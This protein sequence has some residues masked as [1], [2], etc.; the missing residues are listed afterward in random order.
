MRYLT[1]SILASL[2]FTAT[3]SAA[4]VVHETLVHDTTTQVNVT[5]T[6][7][8]V[9]CSSADYGA[10]FLKV[11]IPELA[12]LTLLDHQNLGAGAPCV[13]SGMC[14]PGNEPSDVIDPANP[15]ALVD[16]NVKAIRVDWADADTQ[17]CETT[18]VERVRVNIRGIDF[19]H[20]RSAPLGTRPFADCATSSTVSEEPEQPVQPEPETD[21]PA[22]AYGDD[23]EAEAKPAA[24][25]SAG[26][27][28]TPAGA[29][30]AIVGALLLLR[31][32]RNCA[33][34]PLHS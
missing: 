21:K 31:R 33:S 9:L 24:G 7:A 5:L 32:R 34:A 16:I 10:L 23:D 12:K 30:T 11:L 17:T 25:C 18:L 20:E 26:G 22:D 19:Q 14:A 13:A 8:T 2:A 1:R 15:K 6:D 29:L 4:P 28:G 3:A 27:S